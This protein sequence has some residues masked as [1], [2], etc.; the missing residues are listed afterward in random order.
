[1]KR[2]ALALSFLLFIPFYATAKDLRV[3]AWNIANLHHEAGIESRPG[4]GTERKE[5][6]YTVLR[7]YAEKLGEDDGPA[8]IIALQEIATRAGAHRVFP[9]A[10]YQ[11]VMSQLYERDTANGEN[12]GIYTAVAIRK[13]SGITLVKQEDVE[14]LIIEYQDDR[15]ND[16]ST[17][18]G[19]AVLLNVDGTELW[20]VSVHLKSSCSSTKNVSTSD[21]IHCEIFW[22]QRNPLAEW[23]AEKSAEGTPFIIAGDFNRRFREL[24]YSG[25]FW[26]AINGGD[27]N[28][29]P[30][31]PHPQTVTRKCRT[32]V[33]TSTQP[34]DWIMLSKDIEDWVVPGSFWEE[35]FSYTDVNNAGGSSSKRLS[36]HCPISI[37]LSF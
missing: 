5:N 37:D 25:Q 12:K 2:C 24:E 17:R 3:A 26:T 21:T 13:D 4:I 19:T 27:L 18:S 32:R 33:G 30:L 20:V 35:R 10:E 8:D 36:D 22:Q 1:M 29:P 9:Q 15:G 16:K 14:D 7:E 6:D 28:D 34:I 23:V 11:I 31:V